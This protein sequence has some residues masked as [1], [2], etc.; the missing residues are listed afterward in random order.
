MFKTYLKTAVRN[1][2]KNKL[3]SVINILGLAI[4]IASFIIIMLYVRYESSYDDFFANSDQIYRVY[5]DYKKGDHFEQGDAQVYN[6]SGPALKKEFPEIIDFV[7][8]YPLSESTF[9]FENST[10][11]VTNGYLADPSWFTVFDYPL[12]NGDALKVLS[13]PNTVVLTRKTADEIFGNTNPVGKTLTVNRGGKETTLTVTGILKNIPEN[14]YLKTN[15]LVSFQTIKNWQVDR[16][17]QNWNNNDFFT[18]LL[19]NK[20]T[21]IDVLTKKITEM[22]TPLKNERHNIEPLKSIHLHSDK[23]FEAETN[24]S[25]VQ[26]RFL[27]AIALITLLLSWL[28]YINLSSAKSLERAKEVGIRK[29]SGA[30]KGQLI[31]QFLFESL[32]LNLVAIFLAFIIVIVL[33]PNFDSFTGKSLEMGLSSGRSIL[34]LMGIPILGILLS[35]L[36]SALTLS[37]FNPSTLLKGKV[38]TDTKGAEYRNAFIVVQFLAA[39]VLLTGSITIFKQM[40]F[41]SDQ[42]LGAD[43]NQLISI[44]SNI[45][46][47]KENFG[48]ALETLKEEL[49]KL[50]LIESVSITDSYPG[51]DN[52]SYLMG[53]TYPD[54]TKDGQTKWYFSNVDNDYLHVLGIKLLA[55]QGFSDSKEVN[56]NKVIINETAAKQY[57]FTDPAN[58]VDQTIN[59]WKHDWQ[60]SGVVKDYHSVGLKYHIEPLILRNDQDLAN[61]GILVKLNNVASVSGL[62]KAIGQVRSEW[63]KMFP[64]SSFQYSFVDEKFASSYNEDRKFGKAFGFF[65]LLSIFIASLGLFGLTF[66]RCNLRIKEIGVR[67]VNGAKISEILTMLNRDFVKWV[68]IAFVISTPIAYYAMNKWLENFAYKTELSW[69]IFA[70]AGLL[71]L[72]IAL[73]TVSW[74]SWKAATRNPV[75]ALRYE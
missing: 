75:E 66:Y 72:G 31:F 9:E 49:K 13:D 19:I 36:Y 45:L 8:L 50:P 61:S 46:D 37:G 10:F 24:G 57:G 12:I 25:I 35:G 55:G 48:T 33:L 22:K 62:D 5:M 30:R 6:M 1:L 53:M 47:E 4:G 68:A 60:I 27:L 2:L 69:W 58:A 51:S 43:L 67:K 41:V 16:P 42:P 28:N 71:A 64:K 20:S 21:N 23:P 15:F 34:L 38:R 29:A 65:T 7:R 11:E 59:F 40:S 39:I 63:Q 14:S 26:I 52:S 18:Y 44:K 56:K 70:I 73:L 3:F 54:G 32:L 74:Q 17:D